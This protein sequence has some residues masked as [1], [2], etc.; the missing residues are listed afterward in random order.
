MMVRSSGYRQE[1]K[2]DVPW[3]YSDDIMHFSTL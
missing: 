1:S 3:I 2:F